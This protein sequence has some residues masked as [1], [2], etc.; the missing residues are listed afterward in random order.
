M[1]ESCDPMDCTP[2]GSSVHGIL[3]ARILE[4]VAIPF[5]RG[6]SRF[7]DQMNPCRRGDR[8][9]ISC[10]VGGFFTVWA[11]VKPLVVRGKRILG[12]SHWLGR[13]IKSVYC[14]CSCSPMKSQMRG[15][16]KGSFW[17]FVGCLCPWYFLLKGQLQPISHMINMPVFCLWI[18]VFCI[19]ELCFCFQ[20]DHC[21]C[22]WFLLILFFKK[23]SK[24]QNNLHSKGLCKRIW[25]LFAHELF[26][27]CYLP[28]TIF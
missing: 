5:S 15:E 27:W 21:K 23:S 4:W 19:Y 13:R 26:F 10:V 25:Y 7:M 1:F 8:T 14:S 22:W 28:L 6:S 16:N 2:P 9:L 12:N 17:I 20:K 18:S 3:Q 24:H 11:M